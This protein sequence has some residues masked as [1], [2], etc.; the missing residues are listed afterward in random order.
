MFARIRRLYA[1]IELQVYIHIGIERHS[2]V[3]GLAL[4]RIHIA[5]GQNGIPGIDRRQ[6]YHRAVVGDRVG[7]LHQGGGASQGQGDVIAHRGKKASAVHCRLAGSRGV[8]QR[9]RRRWGG[10]IQME[11][12]LMIRG[13]GLRLLIDHVDVHTAARNVEFHRQLIAVGG[14]LVADRIAVAVQDGKALQGM[15]GI[16]GQGH[17]H[18]LAVQSLDGLRAGGIR[19]AGGHIAGTLS[20]QRDAAGA[21][22]LAG[23]RVLQY[24]IAVLR[25]I[26]GRVNMKSDR[27]MGVVRPALGKV[28]I[29]VIVPRRH[30]KSTALGADHASDGGSDIKFLRRHRNLGDIVTIGNMHRIGNVLSRLGRTA[31]YQRADIQIVVASIGARCLRHAVGA[32]AVAVP[33]YQ[34]SI[35]FGG[36]PRSERHCDSHRLRRHNKLKGIYP[37]PGQAHYPGGRSNNGHINAVAT[38]T[39]HKNFHRIP[40]GSGREHRR[41]SSRGVASSGGRRSAVSEQIGGVSS[42]GRLTDY[43]CNTNGICSA[44]LEVDPQNRLRSRALECRHSKG[45]MHCVPRSAV[46]AAVGERDIRGVGSIENGDAANVVARSHDNIHWHQFTLISRSGLGYVCNGGYIRTSHSLCRHSVAIGEGGILLHPQAI[47]CGSVFLHK[48]HCHHHIGGRHRHFHAAG[49]VEIPGNAGARHITLHRHSRHIGIAGRGIGGGDPIAGG[50]LYAGPRD[51]RPCGR[52]CDGSCS[53]TAGGG[54][55]GIVCDGKRALAQSGLLGGVR[56]GVLPNGCGKLRLLW[57]RAVSI[58]HIEGGIHTGHSEYSL[59]HPALAIVISNAGEGHR[60]VQERTNIGHAV[61]QRALV[62]INTDMGNVLSLGHGDLHRQGIPRL[63]CDVLLVPQGFPDRVVGLVMIGVVIFTDMGDE[64][65]ATGIIKGDHYYHL[66]GGRIIEGCHVE[67]EAAAGG[68][69]DR[70]LEGPGSQRGWSIGGII[71]LHA[72]R[73]VAAEPIIRLSG[74]VKDLHAHA[75]VT[76]DPHTVVPARGNQRGIQGDRIG[77]S[78]IHA[79]KGRTF[80]VL[81]TLKDQTDFISLN[82]LID[83]HDLHIVIRHGESVLPWLS[84]YGRGGHCRDLGVALIDQNVLNLVHSITVG[85]HGDGSV[86]SGLDLVILQVG[87]VGIVVGAGVGIAASDQAAALRLVFTIVKVQLRGVV[88]IAIGLIQHQSSNMRLSQFKL[89]RYRHIAGGHRKGVVQH[90]LIRRNVCRRRCDIP[91]RVGVVD[92]HLHVIVAVPLDRNGHSGSVDHGKGIG[93]RTQNGRDRNRRGQLSGVHC[94]GGAAGRSHFQGGLILRVG[95][96]FA[97]KVNIHA[98]I[99]P[100]R[101]DKGPL[102]GPVAGLGYGRGQE[103]AAVRTEHTHIHRKSIGLGCADPQ[104]LAAGKVDDGAVITGIIDAVA[105]RDLRGRRKRFIIDNE[106]SAVSGKPI[107]VDIQGSG[108]ILRLPLVLEN[109]QVAGVVKHQLQVMLRI[110]VGILIPVAI[111]GA[112]IIVF[113]HTLVGTAADGERA[114]VPGQAD[115]QPLIRVVVLEHEGEH[116]NIECVALRVCLLCEAQLS[117]FKLVRIDLQADIGQLPAGAIGKLFCTITLG[118]RD[119]I[120]HGHN[121]NRIAQLVFHFRVSH[122]VDD[123]VAVGIPLVQQVGVRRQVV[124][125]HGVGK[126][127]LVVLIHVGLDIVG[128]VIQSHFHAVNALGGG[129][130]ILRPVGEDKL[131]DVLNTNAHPENGILRRVIAHIGGGKEAVPLLIGAVIHTGL[132]HRRRGVKQLIRANGVG[133]I[134]AG[135]IGIDP[136]DGCHAAVTAGLVVAEVIHDQLGLG[137]KLRGGIVDGRQRRHTP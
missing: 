39:G 135:G 10:G 48:L 94:L 84:R 17:P 105:I 1:L 35:E 91:H 22:G 30:G 130:G 80:F 96:I 28:N 43:K 24:G 32:L 34:G 64:R 12:H 124:L 3:V 128:I 37:D 6:I 60:H 67:R 15:A 123:L 45:G 8:G 14:P 132:I 115:T 13:S 136:G 21:G 129:V 83:H 61:G 51:G 78:G 25:A 62:I 88:D 127:L 82:R 106:L 27:I 73:P 16:L 47:G 71:D 53:H 108:Q 137:I 46:V 118:G 134:V 66:F 59:F 87:L 103:I 104:F 5:T 112:A 36:F 92:V 41:R 85:L 126:G 95:I 38:G 122:G 100:I 119:R 76:E 55:G 58:L 86:V 125:S 110:M 117:R 57:R 20:Q 9:H 102:I 56:S 77:A 121:V 107:T 44:V 131:V 70:E 90:G 120:A 111:G 116:G 11:G 29:E 75:G 81:H 99:D 69:G 79:G 72:G 49:G 23:H 26:V 4:D 113:A 54:R 50:R 93:S 133:N 19:S 68:A 98:H 97:D 114:G 101:H 33:E 18:L 63:Y 7:G 74:I 2:E 42:A 40:D 31:V 65:C 89:H 52:R 109:I